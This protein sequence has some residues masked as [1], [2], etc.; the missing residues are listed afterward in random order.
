MRPS[1]SS[2]IVD[3]MVRRTLQVVDQNLMETTE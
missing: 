2:A 3:G 1:E